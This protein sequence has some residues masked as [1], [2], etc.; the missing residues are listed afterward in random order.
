VA[1]IDVLEA[2]AQ[3][4]QRLVHIVGIGWIDGGVRCVCCDELGKGW[5]EGFDLCVSLVCAITAV[6]DFVASVCG[7]RECS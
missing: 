6:S 5:G 7:D 3:S 1:V 2:Y 4:L